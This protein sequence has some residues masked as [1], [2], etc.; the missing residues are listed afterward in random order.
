MDSNYKHSKAAHAEKCH[1]FSIR[2][3]N[4]GVASV[5]V[6]AFWMLSGST[7]AAE[8]VAVSPETEVVLVESGNQAETADDEEPAPIAEVVITEELAEPLAELEVAEVEAEEVA[9]VEE[10]DLPNSEAELEE[11]EVT[12]EEV[13]AE[14]LVGETE[15]TKETEEAKDKA[16]EPVV[17]EEKAVAASAIA[18]EET[19]QELSTRVAAT[20]YRVRYVDAETQAVVYQRNYSVAEETVASP[21]E[22]HDFV[23]TVALETETAPALAG[24][25][26]AESQEVTIRNNAIE[27]IVTE[28]GS[29][30]TLFVAVRK[31]AVAANNNDGE[32]Y[33]ALYAANQEGTADD[34]QAERALEGSEFNPETDMELFDFAIRDQAEFDFS[35][36]I[37]ENPENDRLIRENGFTSREE[38]LVLFQNQYLTM[39]SIR[40]LAMLV[41]VLKTMIIIM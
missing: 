32:G 29:N 21:E 25:V 6:A 41:S 20:T 40:L 14:E 7:V 9:A 8:E 2:K 27:A 19:S 31:D 37:V 11:A 1:R 10:A 24:Y 36:Y 4:V 17:T 26:L 18:P 15:E 30:R 33:T 22:A 35:G 16:A 23:V 38:G 28:R 39:R 3:F 12:E 5:A 34:G 13:A